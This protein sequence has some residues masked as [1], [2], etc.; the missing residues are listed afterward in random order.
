MLA[1][2]AQMPGSALLAVHLEAHESAR[3]PALLSRG[4]SVSEGVGEPLELWLMLALAFLSVVRRSVALFE[5]FLAAAAHE[6][7][8][9]EP[10]LFTRL[11]GR[12]SLPLLSSAGGLHDSSAWVRHAREAYMMRAP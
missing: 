8:V 7:S 5:S 12:M 2:V 3:I 11:L 9:F 6:G 10:L 4:A 1:D